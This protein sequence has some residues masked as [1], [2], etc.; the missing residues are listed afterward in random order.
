MITATKM[1]E[2]ELKA[3]YKTLENKTAAVLKIAKRTK[4]SPHTVARHWFS[5][6]PLSGGMPTDTKTLKIIEEELLK[7][8]KK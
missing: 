7:A 1:T 6:A 4:R 8:P 2:K 3:L 5:N